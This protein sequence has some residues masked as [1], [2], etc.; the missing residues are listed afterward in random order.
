MDV[1]AFFD[2]GGNE[3]SLKSSKIKR[4]ASGDVIFATKLIS[5]SICEKKYQST[6]LKWCFVYS[7]HCL[8]NKTLSESPVVSLKP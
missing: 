1:F 5:I 2:G 6:E 7:Y 4:K 3:E 8:Q